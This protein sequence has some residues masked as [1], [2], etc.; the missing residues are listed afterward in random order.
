MAFV[1]GDIKEITSSSE[2]D[3]AMKGLVDAADP[4]GIIV[5]IKSEVDTILGVPILSSDA[6]S[7]VVEAV[8]AIGR[9]QSLYYGRKI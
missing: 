9:L 8:T 3:F 5:G 2:I 4:E 7:E 6:Y 1:E